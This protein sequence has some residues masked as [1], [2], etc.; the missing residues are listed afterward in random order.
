MAYERRSSTFY[1][2][3]D[4]ADP[5]TEFIENYGKGYY[6]VYLHNFITRFH[7]D[8]YLLKRCF[9]NEIFKVDYDANEKETITVRIPD[10]CPYKDDDTWTPS[11]MDARFLETTMMCHSDDYHV[12]L[13][14]ETYRTAINKFLKEVHTTY[15]F[16]RKSRFDMLQFYNITGVGPST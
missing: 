16:P 1:I 8:E 11:E 14:T 12:M 15:T 3:I 13:K 4:C 2:S 5:D 9:I 10:R 6:A 7:N